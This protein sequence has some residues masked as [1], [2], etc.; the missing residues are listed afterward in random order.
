MKNQRLGTEVRREQILDAAVELA[1]ESGFASL[2]RN[3]V[4]ERAKTG[5]GN[6]NTVFG[7]F[8]NLKDCV[9]RRAIVGSDPS[10]LKLLSEGIALRHPVAIAAPEHLKKA[11]MI[12]LAE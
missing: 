10:D 6:V 9:M 11:A 2:R 8:D 5:N 4:A 1:K 7:N 3:Q 12:S